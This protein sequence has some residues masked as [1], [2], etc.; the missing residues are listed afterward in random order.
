MASI[1]PLQSI[2]KENKLLGPNYAEWKMNLEIVLTHDEHKFVLSEPCPPVPATN[3]SQA[4]RDRYER[5]HKANEMAKCYILAS[6]SNVLKHQMQ[7][8]VTAAM[9]MQHLKEMFGG[10]DRTTRHELMRKILTTKM[11]EGTLVQ[12][13]VM[14]M[15]AYL[16]ELEILGAKIDSQTQQD[17]ILNSL[18]S[19]FTQFRLNYAMNNKDYSLPELMNELQVAEGVMRAKG[20]VN[21]AQ[22]SG[23]KAKKWNAKKKKK[24]KNKVATVATN[25]QKKA[26]PEKGKCFHC[27]EDGHWKRNCPKYLASLPAKFGKAPNQGIMISCLLETCLVGSPP[28]SWCV[29]SGSTNHICNML[30]GFQLT[31]QLSDGDMYLLMGDSTSV[32]VVAIGLVSLYFENRVLLLKDCLYVPS[33][34]RNLISVSC[35]IDDGLTVVFEQSLSIKHNKSFICKGTR[36]DG[37]F[38]LFPD[39]YS[40]GNSEANTSKQILPLKRKTPMTDEAYMWHLRLGHINSNRIQRL[41]SDGLISPLDLKNLPVCESCLEGKMTKRPFKGKGNRATQLLELIHTDVCGPMNIQARGGFEY[42]ITFIDD[43]SRYGYVYL[44]KHKSETFE[45]F[46]VFKADVENRLD[47]HIKSLRSDR[48]GEYL[49]REFLDF[50]TANGIRSQ[51]TAPGTPQ[52]NGVAERRNRTL[53]EMVRSMMSHATLPS[54]FW[55]YALETAAYLLNLVPSKSVPKT[56]VELWIGRKPKINYLRIWGCPAHVLR[57]DP[58]KL[59]LRTEV[60]LFVGYPKETKG[61]QFYSPNDHKV[62]V[63][64]NAKYLEDELLSGYKSRSKLVLE[65]MTVLDT[66]SKQPNITEN[67]DNTYDVPSVTTDVEPSTHE[68]CRSGRI[69]RPPVRYLEET[70]VVEPE[71]ESDPLNYNEALADIDADRWITAMKSE[72]ESMYSNNVWELVEAPEGIKPIGCKWVYK[73]KRGMDGKVETFKA[74]LVAKG[75]TQIEGIDYDETFSPVAMFKSIRILLSI[76]AHYDYEI[77]QMDV[78][79]AFLNGNLQEEIYMIQPDGFVVENQEHMVCKLKK[80]I[81]GLKQASRSWNI[82]FNEAV[83]SFGFEQLPD[84]PCVYKRHHEKVIMF[85]VLYVD[86]ILLIGNDVGTLSAV[87]IWLSNQFDMKDLG[88]ASYVLGIKLLRDR[89]NKMLGL[90]QAAYI[91]KI[92][93]RYNMADSKKGSLPFRHGIQLSREQCPKTPKEEEHMRN[94]PYASAVGSLMYVMLCTRPDICYAV[95]MVSRYQSNPGPEHW[96]AVKHI[97]KYLRRTRDYMLVYQS[98]ELLP[99]GYSDSDFQS[100]HSTMEA[101]YVAASEAAKEAYW[102]RKFLMDLEVVREGLTPI[103][104]HCDNSGAVANSKEPRSHK[105]SKHIERKYHIIREYVDRGEIVVTKIASTN[106]LADPFTKTLAQKSFDSHLEGM[107]H[108]PGFKTRL[109]EEGFAVRKLGFLRQEGGHAEF[110]RVQS[111]SEASPVGNEPHKIAGVRRYS[112]TFLPE[113]LGHCRGGHFQACPRCYQIRRI[114]T[115]TTQAQLSLLWNGTTTEWFVPQRGLRQGDP[116][117]P[118]LFVFCVQKLGSLIDAA[119]KDRVWKPVPT[120]RNGPQIS[121]LMFA[122]DLL[123]FGEASVRRVQS[124]MQILSKFCAMSGQRVNTQKSRIYFSKNTK[125]E[126]KHG[127]ARITNLQLSLAGWATLIKAVTEAMPA[128]HMQTTR[129]PLGICHAIDKANRQFLWGGTNAKRKMHL[130]K[131]DIICQPKES[132]GLGLRRLRDVNFALLGKLGWQ[133]I[134]E[135]SRLWVQVMLHKYVQRNRARARGATSYSWRSIS[136][137][138]SFLRKGIQWIVGTSEAIR[139]WTDKWIDG[140]PLERSVDQPL[141]TETLHR[142]VASYWIPSF[143]WDWESIGILPSAVVIAL[144]NVNL[145]ITGDHADTSRWKLSPNGRYNCKSA[146][147]ELSQTGDNSWEARQWMRVWKSHGIHRRKMFVWLVRH[148]KILTRAHLYSRGLTDSEVW[149]EVLHGKRADFPEIDL[150]LDL[151]LKRIDGVRFAKICDPKNYLFMFA[152]DGISHPRGK[153]IKGF[154]GSIDPCSVLEA[155]IRA[156]LLGLELAWE[157]GVRKVILESD[158]TTTLSSIEDTSIEHHHFSVIEDIRRMLERDW[159]VS[160]CHVWREANHVADDLAKKGLKN[161]MHLVHVPDIR[162]DYFL[163]LDVNGHKW[164]HLVTMSSDTMQIANRDE[165][166][167][168]KKDDTSQT[169]PF[170]KLLSQADRLDWILMALGTLGSIVHGLAQP[171]GYFLLGK[172][173]DAFGNNINHPDEMVDAL[174]KVVP[175]VWYMAIA[176]FPA[177]ILEIGCWMYASERQVTRLRLTFLKAVLSQEIG[178]FDTDLTSGKIISGISSHMSIIQDA[179]GEKLGH[180]LSCFATFFSGVLI[181]LIACWEVSLLALF[182]VPMIL[183]IGATYTKRMNAISTIRMSFLSEATVMVEQTI[184]HIKTVFA[185]VGEN[186]AIKSFSECIE[187]QIRLSKSEA[188]IKGFGTGMFQTVTFCSW[189][190]IVWVGAIV[191]VAGKARGGD[192]IAA[193]M[194]ILFGAISLTYAAPD[195]QIFNQAK[196][197]GQEV[198]Q[199]IERKPMIYT[200]REGKKLDL[201][202]GNIDIH[203]VH[204]YYPSRK[205]TLILQEFSLSIPAGM[206]VALVGSSGCGKSTIMSLITRFYDPIKGEILIDNHNIKDLDL[207]SLRRNIGL[208]SQ[209]PTLFTGNIKN[210]IMAGNTSADDDQ[211]QNAAQMANAHSFIS[212]FPDQYSTEVGQRG[213]QLSGGQKQRIAIARAILKNPP[214]LLLDEATSA[215]DTESE[216]LVQAALETAMQGRTVILIAHRLSTIVNADMIAV[217]ENGTVAETGTHHELLTNNQFYHNLFEMQNISKESDTRVE[218]STEDVASV[219]T[220]SSSQYLDQ[221]NEPSEKSRTPKLSLKDKEL[222]EITKKHIFFRIWFGLKKREVLKIAI[223]S[224]AAAFTGISKPFFGFFIITIGV[225]YYKDDSKHKVGIYSI[226]FASIGFLSLFAHT[227]QHYLFGEVGEKAMRNLRQALYSVILRN[228]LA[229]FEKPKNNVGS[230]TS[231]VINET[232]TV[233]TIISDRMSVIVQCI[234]SILIATIVSIKVNWR[235][236]LV[237]WAVM[238]CHF[239]GGLIQAKS[240]KGFSSGSNAAYSELV[241]LVSESA[242]NIKTVASFCQEEH[243]IEKAKA[244]LKKPLMISRRQSVKYGIIQGVSLCLWNI[245]HAVALWYTI[246]LVERKQASFEDGIRSYQIFSLTVPSITELWTL[247]PTVFSAISV[248]TPVFQTLDRETEIEPDSPEQSPCKSIKGDIE[249]RNVHFSYPSREEITVLDNFNLKIEAGSKVALVGPSGAGKSSVLALLLRFYD[250]KEGRVLIDGYDIRKYNLRQLRTRIGLVQQE[251]LLFSF[252]IRDNICYGNEGASEAEI[253]QAAMDANIHELISNLPRGYDTSVGE[254]GCQLSG[255]QKQRIA[256]ARTLLKKPAIMLL[257]EATSALDAESERS[258]INALESLKLQTTHVTVAHR[259]STVINSDTIVVMDNGKVVE[260]GTHATLIA[261]NDGVYARLSRLQSISK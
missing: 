176:T 128:Y 261:A 17:M 27:G 205:E 123:L 60:C 257:D 146:Y 113:V 133:V 208:V 149:N 184:S 107:A 45:K 22:T 14:R 71:L 39:K 15:M 49:S 37:L 102:L 212:Q 137:T 92:L 180:F 236:G 130:L 53:M 41:V 90:S 21:F 157:A 104:L 55:G 214:I 3:E 101:E 153:W 150:S 35:L 79:T 16:N 70:L 171:I 252:S 80:S 160:L 99:M 85:L 110:A 194:S 201:I 241:A 163:S 65:E 211:I 181:A 188:F 66:T 48:G 135:E 103:T 42:F 154:G 203:D 52:Q 232:S 131:W 5:W 136:A 159:E 114:M 138:L 218:D 185:F 260:M 68:P 234:S 111:G 83:K 243:V 75:Y 239:I 256:I 204:F 173:L 120:S 118:Y 145:D 237:A 148:G 50:L 95:G 116:L 25:I 151:L 248:L 251:P 177:G 59:E 174:K 244:T 155:E 235:M 169:L 63:S 140:G 93:A 32:P 186:S 54:S 134:T 183:I 147:S 2:L 67:I 202:N 172:A 178:A 200:N 165:T 26:K 209:E 40:V 226:I 81:Y 152:R 246:I 225:A 31:R 10:Q 182:V 258:V 61:G 206:V 86:D 195:M 29:D 109:C 199:V 219:Q 220:E 175:Y 69:I 253:I 213:V 119:V 73:R 28:G 33:I 43:Y 9:M 227:L 217:V 222:K 64:T 190:L 78:K 88:E 46:K 250:V 47:K 231:R 247:I 129:I 58:D 23:T 87:K 132:G 144:N 96:V 77:W 38:L 233:K 230:L 12:E 192:V 74:R 124:A 245:A 122:D 215:L 72:L 82:R 166:E 168:S 89:K 229:W 84:E 94:V 24:G 20:S 164:P 170:Y 196:A 76:A 162:S 106:N 91:D 125:P 193:V 34:R 221:L 100:D 158:S 240:A 112:T 7:E 105:R 156:I 30:Q 210:N 97:L 44:M 179:I 1:S 117:S 259:L 19:S 57:K 36:K 207:K 216:K 139:F 223:G 108:S 115:C 198:F 143:G 127:I 98:E 18:P 141:D 254:K 62:F 238:P 51:L 191:V 242:T 228:E 224:S 4:V 11:T 13:H 161:P 121:H 189:A 249:F 8:M 255:G 167:T 197:A 56:P 126:T 142:T 187:K 6:V